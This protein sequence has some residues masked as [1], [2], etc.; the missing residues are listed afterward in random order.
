MNL[1]T[2]PW[3]PTVWQDGRAKTVSLRQ[4]FEHGHEIRDLVLRPHERIAVMRLLVCIAQAALDGPADYDDWKTGR[5]RMAPLADQYLLRWRSA[6]GLFDNSGRFLQIPDL[7]KPSATSENDEEGEGNSASKLDLSLAT[8]NN[9]TLFD[10]TGG[11]VRAFEA[12]QLALMLLTFQCFSPGGRIGVALW[13]GKPTAGRGSSN[14][15]PCLANGM[16]HTLLRGD[17]LLDSVH[18][19]LL[20]KLQAQQLFGEGGWGRPVWEFRPQ[21]PAD[22]EAVRNANRTYLG[23]LVA[24]AR[25]IRLGA[26]GLHLVLANGLDY[27]CYEDGW[28]EPSA[29]IVARSVKGQPSRQ[30]LRTSIDRA[31]WRDLHALTVKN[32]GGGPGGPAPLQNI[33]EDEEA[34]DL[35]VGGLLTNKAKPVDTTES[36]FHI[37]AA[38]LG[39]TS[40]RVY[41]DGVRQA[42][43]HEFRLRR[44]V[45]VYHKELGDNLDRPEMMNRRRQIQRN[46]AGQFWTDIEQA[47]PRL[48]EVA[49]EPERLG[50]TRAWRDT[51]W[52]QAVRRAARA[53][54]E[55]ACPHETPRQMRAYALG[56]QTFFAP[57]TEQAPA[58]TEDEVRA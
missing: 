22:K 49:A 58:E 11:A 56:L 57:L 19:N 18:R 25:A 31:A 35:W 44:A 7:E 47:V 21:S 28:R 32:V 39:D 52:G 1:T 12:S 14:H 24:L 15:A 23:R 2:D 38:M 33:S 50:L 3:I 4:A 8:G 53:A 13:G 6:F 5:A 43:S 37:P 36:V 42:E 10:N 29:T 45:S 41:E 48:L 46:A 20:N 54:Y 17:S 9:S 34:F 30:V 55:R 51:V 26:N 27:P 16:L 40:R